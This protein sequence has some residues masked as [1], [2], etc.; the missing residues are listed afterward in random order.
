VPCWES[1]PNGVV[2]PIACCIEQLQTGFQVETS[3]A[4]RQFKEGDTAFIFFLSSLQTDGEILMSL[5]FAVVPPGELDQRA[6]SPGDQLMGGS[7]RW[8]NS[9]LRC[10]VV[11]CLATWLTAGLSLLD[12]TCR[13]GQSNRPGCLSGVGRTSDIG[14]GRGAFATG[15]EASKTIRKFSMAWDCA[16]CWACCKA[17]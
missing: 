4:R 10:A 15:V 5:Y 16:R 13:T 8:C 17:W 11:A 12:E 1:R 2:I 7:R 14:S 3:I 6:A 9:G